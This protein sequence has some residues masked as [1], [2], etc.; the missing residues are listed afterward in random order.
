MMR[1]RAVIL[2]ILAAFAG[3]PE[4]SYSQA[5]EARRNQVALDLS[6]VGGSVSYARRTGITDLVGLELGIAGQ[7]IAV[8]RFSNAHLKQG[9]ILGLGHGGGFWRHEWSDRAEIDAGLTLGFVLHSTPDDD[10]LALALFGGPYITPMVGWRTVKFGPRLTAA[11]V[12]ESREDSGLGLI[13]DP[14]TA[15]ITLR[16]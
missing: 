7:W 10:D 11:Y 6:L 2:F 14:I 4:Q 8:E 12:Y 3:V 13:L 5:V 9:D 16:F 1:R 15:R